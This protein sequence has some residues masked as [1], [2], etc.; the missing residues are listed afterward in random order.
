MW[1]VGDYSGRIAPTASEAFPQQIQAIIPY[2]K[3]GLVKQFVG[4]GEQRDIAV[5]RL[6]ACL[7]NKESM[8]DL[9]GL[10]LRTLPLLPECVSTLNVS[11]NHLS[12]LPNLPE[13]L[14]DLNCAGNTLTSLS[15]LPR[16]CNY[17]IVHKT[18]Y[19][20]YKTYLLH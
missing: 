13:G 4:A 9:A 15:A 10:N 8:L 6:C 11:N 3:P 5:E 12:A 20:N 2:G 19:P 16:R 7:C 14:T 17:L 18:I 1:P